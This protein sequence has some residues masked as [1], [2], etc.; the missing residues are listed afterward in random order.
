MM[1]M[2]YIQQARRWIGPREVLQAA[3]ASMRLRF[4]VLVG[5][6]VILA[7][8]S[9]VARGEDMP[10]ASVLP[11]W[12]FVGTALVWAFSAGMVFAQFTSL[13][14]RIES[15]EGAAV[16]KDVL[17]ETLTGLRGEI[18][19]VR[20]LLERSDREWRDSLHGSKE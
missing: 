5:S 2:A 1:L 12:P 16:K 4:W 9:V 19:A 11:W 8:V 10:Q 20:A 18:A 6:G 7:T 17:A 14:S 13:K 15:L 3:P